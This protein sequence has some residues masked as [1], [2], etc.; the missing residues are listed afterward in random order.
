[1][2]HVFVC[3]SRG[4]GDSWGC[5]GDLLKRSV[6]CGGLWFCVSGVVLVNVQIHA[7]NVS[8]HV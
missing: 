4:G 7:E 2:L 1:M 8:L 5:G 3:L 6:L